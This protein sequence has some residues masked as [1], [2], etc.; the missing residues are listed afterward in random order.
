MLVPKLNRIFIYTCNGKYFEQDII[1]FI[2]YININKETGCWEWIGC[3]RNDGYGCFTYKYNDKYKLMGS[4][5]TS[6]EMFTG[7]LISVGMCACHKCDN[8]KCV[9]PNH[10]FL[11]TQGENIKDMVNKNRQATGNMVYKSKLTVEQVRIIRDL[12]NS[13]KYNMPQLVIL[14]NISKSNISDIISNYI[15]KDEQYIRIRFDNRR[16]AITTLDIVNKIRKLW[17]SGKY[18]QKQLA[19][20]FGVSRQNIGLIINNKR[21][22]EQS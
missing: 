1:K 19:N 3:M 22:V 9:N 18:L 8:R 21:W 6:Y 10:L 2:K 16:N 12:Y 20:M 11:G 15:W 7:K 14:F 4:H 17:V 5:R 13:Y